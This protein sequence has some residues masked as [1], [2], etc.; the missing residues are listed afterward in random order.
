MMGK[1]CCFYERMVDSFL[2]LSIDGDADLHNG[3]NLFHLSV[4]DDITT[5]PLMQKLLVTD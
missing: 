5:M 1:N 4:Q 3:V 2:F